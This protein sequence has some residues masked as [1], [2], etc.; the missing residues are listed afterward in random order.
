MRRTLKTRS[1][2]GHLVTV[3]LVPWSLDRPGLTSGFVPKE[4]AGDLDFIAVHLY[5]EKD[6]VK[7]AIETLSGFAV[8]KPVIIEEMFPLNCSFPEFERFLDESRKVAS[9]WIGFYWG[10]TLEEYRKSSTIQDALMVRWL[11]MF[12]KRAPVQT[13]KS[14]KLIEWGWDEPDNKFMRQNVERMEELPFDGVAFHAVS[15]KGGNVTWEMWGSRRFDLAEFQHAIDDLKATS[16]RR[17]ADRFLRV[18]VTPGKV[19]WFD[20]QPHSQGVREAGHTAGRAQAAYREERFASVD[21]LREPARS[22][23]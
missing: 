1:L 19:D 23:C 9:G 4:I 5:P 18:N 6:K 2:K 10:K 22:R 17:L 15:S 8:G 12:Q 14:K 13:M 16:F 7:E 11:E 20:D 3:G 21:N